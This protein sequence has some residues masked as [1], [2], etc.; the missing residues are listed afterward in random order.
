LV[1]HVARKAAAFCGECPELRGVKFVSRAGHD[2][3]P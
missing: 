1:R 3:S 2:S